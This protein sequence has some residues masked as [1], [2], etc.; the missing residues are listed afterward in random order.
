[1]DWKILVDLQNPIFLKQ[2]M[3]LQTKKITQFNM[4][5]NHYLMFLN[6][7]ISD[8]DLINLIKGIKAKKMYLVIVINII[9]LTKIFSQFPF[10]FILKMSL[11]KSF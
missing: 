9:C 4:K 7:P 6:V 11:L 5:W 3:F 8:V 1:M 10:D 2:K